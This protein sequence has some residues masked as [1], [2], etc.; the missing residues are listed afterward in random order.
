M[1][2]KAIL[3]NAAMSAQKVRLVANEIRGLKVD[4]ALQKLTY[5]RKKASDLIKK[6]LDSAIAN[7]E[8]NQGADIDELVVSK[9]CI[10]EASVLKR[11]SARA[12]GRGTRILKRHCH[13]HVEVKVADKI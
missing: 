8:H 3:R 6:V 13:I 7:I 10:N 12:K 2:D 5:M 9:I 4:L 1:Q 11:F